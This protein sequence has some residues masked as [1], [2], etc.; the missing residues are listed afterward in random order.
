MANDEAAATRQMEGDS[1]AHRRERLAQFARE[2]YLILEDAL[3]AARTGALRDAVNGIWQAHLGA[4]GSP[5]FLHLFGFHGRDALFLQLLDHP[6]VLPLIRDL[7]GANIYVYHSHLDVHSPLASGSTFSY[8]WH[9][10]GGEMNADLAVWPQPRLAVKVA[11]FLSDVHLPDRGNLHVIPGSHK[12]ECPDTGDAERLPDSAVPV[13]APAGAA[14]LFDRRLWHSRGPNHSSHTRRALF[15]AYA[16]RWVRP[17]DRAEVSPEL[18]GQLTAVQRQMLGSGEGL[19]G[20]H[21]PSAAD[22]PLAAWVP[23]RAVP[24]GDRWG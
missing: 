16:H 12:V 2:G 21:V 8:S 18:Q 24:P 20:F 3:P 19:R 17:R 7:I 10:D 15:Y 13:L 11:Y 1:S 4:G 14:V 9:R 6:V 5:Q 22:V 23:E